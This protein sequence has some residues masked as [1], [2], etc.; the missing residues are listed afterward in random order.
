MNMVCKPPPDFYRPMVAIVQ[1]AT[2]EHSLVS[3]VLDDTERPELHV[4]E[5]G[6]PGFLGV[7]PADHS[8]LE[9]G[10]ASRYVF[11]LMVLR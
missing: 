10:A 7:L 8:F 11:A 1:S 3:F 6:T 5:V 2:S 4:T 9:P